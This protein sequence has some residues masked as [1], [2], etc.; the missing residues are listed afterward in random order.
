MGEGVGSL[1]TRSLQGEANE[2]MARMT[3][4]EVIAKAKKLGRPFRAEE[5]GARGKGGRRSRG[6]ALA[7]ALRKG[8]VIKRNGLYEYV[9]QK[10]APDTEPP[11][12]DPLLLGPEAD[13]LEAIYADLMRGL[14]KIRAKQVQRVA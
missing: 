8:L 5:I 12:D 4:D 9:G 1:G 14:E 13:F 7:N 10:P 2:G 3:V 11:V 6:A